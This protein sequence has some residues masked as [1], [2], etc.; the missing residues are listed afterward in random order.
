MKTLFC[1]LGFICWIMPGVAMAKEVKIAFGLSIPPYVFM[2]RNTGF[3]LEVFRKALEFK[4]HVLVPIYVPLARLLDEFKEG[5]VDAIQR[6]FGINFTNNKDVFVSN[7]VVRYYA[8]MIWLKESPFAYTEPRSL[9]GHS[10]L[11]F[12]GATYSKAISKACAKVM[13]TKNYSEIS[14]QLAQARMLLEGRVKFVVA[15]KYIFKYFMKEAVKQ[16]VAKPKVLAYHLI[17]PEGYSEKA[18]FHDKNLRDDFNAGL[19]AIHRNGTFEK[20]Q[21]EFLF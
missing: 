2:D 3:E 13:N 1:C 21:K 15:D 19:K 11:A 17:E 12:Q 9:E 4:H 16:G 8:S 7:T 6:D 18:I 20:L 10:V 14:D 5:K